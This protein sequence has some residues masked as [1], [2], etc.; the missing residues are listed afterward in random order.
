M[1]SQ[2]LIHLINQPVGPVVPYT[3]TG[4]PVETPNTMK[5]CKGLEVEGDSH[6]PDS[7]HGTLYYATENTKTHHT[8]EKHYLLEF[9]I[10]HSTRMDR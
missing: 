5:V 2:A 1:S 8:W 9:A 7:Y 4:T 3:R 10:G 6:C